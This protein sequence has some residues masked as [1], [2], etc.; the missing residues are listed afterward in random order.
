MCEEMKVKLRDK[1]SKEKKLPAEIITK[2]ST[3]LT[4]IKS[5]YNGSQSSVTC[6]Q[7]VTNTPAV[8]NV[9]SNESSTNKLKIEKVNEALKQITVKK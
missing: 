7:T 4:P 3:S 2:K 6:S 1:R 8:N 9:V 5:V